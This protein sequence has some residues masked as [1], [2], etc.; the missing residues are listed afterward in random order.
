MKIII[1]GSSGFI[2]SHL[3]EHFLKLGNLVHGADIKENNLKNLVFIKINSFEQDFTI[4]FKNQQFE[5]CINASGSASVPYSIQ[6]PSED[7]RLNVSNVNSILHS[8]RK[9]NPNCKFINFSSAAVY[10]N[11]SS[12]PIKEESILSPVSPYGFH[13]MISE[14]ICFEFWKLYD[15]R[16]ISLRVFSAY[17]PQLKKQLFWDLYQKSLINKNIELYGSGD[18]TR[19]YIYIEDLCQAVECI[20]N[21]API[22]GETINVA[23]GIETSIKTATEFFAEFFDPTIKYSFNGQ[24]KKGDP[25]NWVADISI[26]KSLGYTPSFDLRKGL[27]K[28]VEW[29]KNQ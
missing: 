14:Q 21:N 1:I 17:G 2:G 27:T 23:S 3:C 9:E 29:L 22:K 4:L 15:I 25:N 11:P 20:I 8:I 10:G 28:H 18:E 6:N 5:I 19:D 13:K 24:T 12:L 7:F 26:L 16:T